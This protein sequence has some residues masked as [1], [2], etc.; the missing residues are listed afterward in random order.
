MSVNTCKNCKSFDNSLH[1][2]DVR[3]ENM[4]ICSKISEV[5]FKN[6]KICKMFQ[7]NFTSVNDIEVNEP[8]YVLPNPQ[9]TM[10]EIMEFINPPRIVK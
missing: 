3:T 9:S 2:N 10:F 6:D 5:V 7:N 1:R 8:I 4:G